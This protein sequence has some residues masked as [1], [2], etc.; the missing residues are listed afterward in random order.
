MRKQALVNIIILFSLCTACVSEDIVDISSKHQ[1]KIFVLGFLSPDNDVEIYLGRTIPFGTIQENPENY[2]VFDAEVRIQEEGGETYLL[3]ETGDGTPLYRCSKSEFPISAGK[4]YTLEV[5]HNDLPTVQANTTVPSAKAHWQN[6][7]IS[8]S[9][10]YYYMVSGNWEKLPHTDLKQYGVLIENLDPYRLNKGTSEGI[11]P[12]GNLISLKREIFLANGERGLRATLLTKDV[13]YGAYS[14][15][16]DLTWNVMEDFSS[17]GFAEIISGFKGVIPQHSN[18]E[19]G[20]GVFG[21][22]LKD[23]RDIAL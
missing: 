1:P 2:K 13:H 9:E 6:L 5:N 14:N 17:A 15:I 12:T 21:S 11:F 8:P 4:T 3:K 22:Y 7:E 10:M 16:A 23:T 20:V 19:N 18:V